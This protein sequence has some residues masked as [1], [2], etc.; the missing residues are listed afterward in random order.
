MSVQ[1]NQH[2]TRHAVAKNG[3]QLI[4]KARVTVRANIKQLVEMRPGEETVLARVGE[5]SCRPSGRRS[6]TKRYWKRSI[7]SQSLC[8]TRVSIWAPAF[9]I[10]SIDMRHRCGA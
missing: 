2:A 9:E 6:R 10:L 1:R 3:I 5:G 8:L 7:P 4:A